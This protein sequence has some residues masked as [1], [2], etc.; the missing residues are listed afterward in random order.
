V[1]VV[2]PGPSSTATFANNQLLAFN[3]PGKRDFAQPGGIVDDGASGSII[4][5][6]RWISS[7]RNGCALLEIAAN[8][9]FHYVAGQ[10]APAPVLN[11]GEATYTL[12]GGTR[13]TG[14]DGGTPGILNRATLF[15]DFTN[16]RVAA[17]LN[18]SY[19]GQT[20]DVSTPGGANAS[21]AAQAGMQLN[22]GQATFGGSALAVTGCMTPASCGATVHGFLAGPAAERAGLIYA[23]TDGAPTLTV[24]GAA[25]LRR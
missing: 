24:T 2:G 7:Y 14:S 19:G 1:E 22:R 11:R 4:G 12:I 23:I 15:A 8:Q 9:G 16:A 18:V 5:W 20:Y 17:A 25:A 6:G 21:G 3:G 13:P 10:P